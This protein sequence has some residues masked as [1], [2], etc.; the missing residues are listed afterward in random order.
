MDNT[1]V[2]IV[3]VVVLV[4]VVVIAALVIVAMLRGARAARLRGRFGS[5]YDRAV[6]AV[7][8]RRAEAELHDRESR[9]S[10]FELRPLRP[11]ERERYI[12]AWRTIQADFVDQPI[13]AAVRADALLSEI[14]AVRGYPVSDFDQRAAD[15]SVGHAD[16]VSNYRAAHDIVLRHGRGETTTED[17]RQAMIHYRGLFE[18]L[19]DAPE[20]QLRR[21]S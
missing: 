17:L 14:M 10:T 18:E 16:L 1:T 20:A 21:A 8:R 7:G 6:N 13:A 3:T 12:D 5:E 2:F 19:V 4:A 15:L 11:G 9:V